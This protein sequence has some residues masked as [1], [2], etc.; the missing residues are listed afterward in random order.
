MK[1][2]YETDSRI[3][4]TILIVIGI[5]ILFGLWYRL[6]LLDDNYRKGYD[7]FE[8][9]QLGT[10]I[11]SGYGIQFKHVPDVV[12]PPG[13]PIVVGLIDL[14]IEDPE[15]SGKIVGLCS[16][17]LSLL[18]V[19]KIGNFLFEDIGLVW[20]LLLLFATNS[21][22]LI[23]ASNGYS[24]SLFTSVFLLMVWLSL[25]HRSDLIQSVFFGFLWSWL[26]LIRPEGMIIGFI[27]FVWM[28]CLKTRII[29]VI[30]TPLIFVILILPYL[31]FLRENTGVWQFSG[32]TYL[33]LVM[34]ELESP[35]QKKTAGTATER[36][37]IIDRTLAD[38][39][40]SFG[41]MTY[42]QE[43]ENDIFRRIPTNLGKLF[44]HYVWSFSIV[45]AALG[46][47]GLF[48]VKKPYHYF[49]WLMLLPVLTYVIF[50]VLPRTVS[51]FHW[52][53]MIGIVCGIDGLRK[54]MIGRTMGQK[55]I[56]GVP[57][58]VGAVI[59]AYQFRSVIKI[60][61]LN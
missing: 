54:L 51:V 55:W 10:S 20:M 19:Y 53:F 59:M 8:Y 44:M 40:L 52:I 50:F 5:I 26:Y 6:G 1:V 15:W 31:Y 3:L 42:W 18:L 4:K 7:P 33:N 43:P 60:I 30:L 9:A 11:W 13:F 21:N 27:L 49:L 39:S 41:F 57:W 34:G 28:V 48:Y 45:G 25:N 23:N 37:K 14:I 16:F 36:Y 12:L 17:L 46:F 61:I 29:F 58:F 56:S 24:E 22:L 2:N 47:L 32:K 38:P 35:Y